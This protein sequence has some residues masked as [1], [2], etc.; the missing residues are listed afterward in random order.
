M[1]VWMTYTDVCEQ[2]KIKPG[3]LAWMVHKRKIPHHRVGPRMVRFSKD[4]I[5]RWMRERAV[6]VEKQPT[7]DADNLTGDEA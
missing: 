2:L 5:E 4:E 1:S 7:R 3:T 6:G